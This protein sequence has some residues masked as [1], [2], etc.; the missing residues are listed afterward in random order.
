M[1][2]ALRRRTAPDHQRIE[3]LLGLQEAFELGWYGRVMVGFESFLAQWEPHMRAALPPHRHE[4]FDA[5]RRHSLAQR[6]L[7]A[8]GLARDDAPAG[9]RIPLESPSA[10]LGSL[11]VME[12][13]SL[14]GQLIARQLL[15]QHGRDGASGAAYFSGARERTGSQ[16]REFLDLLA[17]DDADGADHDAACAAAC[18]T[19]G[20]LHGHFSRVLHAG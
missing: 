2:A 12:G 19:F 1:L 13:S 3:S 20:A 17:R 4:W 7:V 11:Y 5:R 10:A 15:R 18:A 14:G 16:W 6:D 9:W 8:L